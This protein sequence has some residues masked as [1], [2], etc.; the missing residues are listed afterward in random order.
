[1]T[2]KVSLNAPLRFNPQDGNCAKVEN[3]DIFFPEGKREE[4]AE[5]TRQAK[6]VCTT[7]PVAELC[8]L[9]AIDNDDWGIWG[10]ATRDERNRLR[11][12]NKEIVIHLTKLW[13]GEFDVPTKDE[14]KIFKA[15]NEA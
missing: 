6:T 11:K 2:R 13:R 15:K 10:G 5:L 8:I 9:S 14:N 12:S 7:C 3:P 1:M 4:V